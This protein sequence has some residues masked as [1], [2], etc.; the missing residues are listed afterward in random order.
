MGL[1]IK[2]FVEGD[3][4]ICEFQPEGHHQS[5]D[6][7]VAGGIIGTLF[8]CHLN[9]TATHHLM[10]SN[11]L[12]QPPSTV[13]I[14]F[15]VKFI[16]PTPSNGPLRLRAKVVDS[17]SRRATVLGRLEAGGDVT[18]TCRALFAV[19]DEGHPA[20]GRWQASR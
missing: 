6:G 13:T 1:R 4:G 14:E 7:A 16:K 5:F 11:E 20:Y 12:D 3:E 15:T 10:V 18:A 17:T 9:W 8:D 19:V 2:T